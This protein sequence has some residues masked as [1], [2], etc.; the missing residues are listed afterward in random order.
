MRALSAPNLQRPNPR[1]HPAVPSSLPFSAQALSL[2]LPEALPTASSQPCPSALCWGAALPEAMHC[3]GQGQP[4]CPGPRWLSPEPSEPRGLVDGAS[5]AARLPVPHQKASY[6]HVPG[7][8]YLRISILRLAAFFG[9]KR[10]EDS[11]GEKI[12]PERSPKG[13]GRNYPSPCVGKTVAKFIAFNK[14]EGLPMIRPLYHTP[15]SSVC[16]ALPNQ[17]RGEVKLA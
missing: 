13:T 17:C 10:Q 12:I 3:P 6:L 5:G 11:F 7:K 9:G 2:R 4:I 16:G 14:T 15:S 1:G 8:L